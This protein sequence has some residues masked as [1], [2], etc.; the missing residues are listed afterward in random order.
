M[1]IDLSNYCPQA[2]EQFKATCYAYA[3]GYT[4]YSTKYNIVNNITDRNTIEGNAFSEGF[5]AS[6]VRNNQRVWLRLINTDCGMH[7]TANLALDVLVAS[8]CVTIKDFTCDC[9][10]G[11]SNEVLEQAK[12]N[13]IKGYR[14]ITT[15]FVSDNDAV[16]KIIDELKNSNPVIT[17]IHQTDEFYDL[18]G[19]SAQLKDLN[20]E[21]A[22]ANHVVCIVGYDSEQFENEG[23]FLVKNNYLK[24]AN[25]GLCWVKCADFMHLID[26]SYAMNFN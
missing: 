10:I 15:D 19:A 17:A 7:G 1:K 26:T 18:S 20:N 3:V 4:A 8:G 25:K 13:K 22:F 2:R 16:S 14:E 12:K 11:A 9:E 21:K 5:V 6:M 24:W 23:A